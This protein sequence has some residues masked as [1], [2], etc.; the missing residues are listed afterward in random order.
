MD[1][2]QSNP[3]SCSYH[4]AEVPARLPV[5]TSCQNGHFGQHSTRTGQLG[6]FGQE[7]RAVNKVFSR[8]LCGSDVRKQ[9]W[10]NSVGAAEMSAAGLPE[11]QPVDVEVFP[12]IKEGNPWRWTTADTLSRIDYWWSQLWKLDYFLL[13][14][15][16]YS[17]FLDPGCFRSWRYLV[18]VLSTIDC[19][20]SVCD[21]V[22]SHWD[23]TWNKTIPNDVVLI[24]AA[25]KPDC[26][27]IWF[28]YML[29]IIILPSI[30]TILQFWSCCYS[31]PAAF[32]LSLLHLPKHWQVT[33]KLRTAGD[34]MEQVQCSQV[35]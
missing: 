4:P 35:P 9:R 15:L 11:E 10:H 24:S 32:W 14:Y 23:F 7:F 27:T 19:I 21:I 1:R 17:F 8:K 31:L 16:W 5:R 3:C 2:T 34:Q 18:T 26:S 25:C 13:H 6:H 22:P 28:G 30:S 20:L 29:L 33:W 12:R